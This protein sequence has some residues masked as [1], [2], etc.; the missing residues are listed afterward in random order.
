MGEE[1]RRDTQKSFIWLARGGPIGQ[2]V[3]IFK[4]KTN[5]ASENVNERPVLRAAA[6]QALSKIGHTDGL[7]A[8][9]AAVNS[10]DPNLRAAALEALG[11][12]SGDEVDAVI[13]DGFR[14][15]FFRTRISAAKAARVR[16]LTA[17]IP[18][19]RF[20]VENDTVPSVREE[21]IR[22]L[23]AIGGHCY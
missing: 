10:N 17:A 13:L 19:L 21:S 12:F 15:S 22:A 9:I 18:Y 4:Y 14:D 5:R 16:E 3:V 7:G 11:P 20:R 1:G 6:V 8:I 2:I 23:G